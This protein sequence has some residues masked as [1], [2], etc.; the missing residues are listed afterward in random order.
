M[1]WIILAPVLT[2][3][4]MTGMIVIICFLTTKEKKRD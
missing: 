4:I 2:T 3:I 1:I